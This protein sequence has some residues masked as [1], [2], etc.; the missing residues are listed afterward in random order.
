[1]SALEKVWDMYKKE[2]AANWKKRSEDMEDRW[3]NF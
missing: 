2:N 1:M 3:N